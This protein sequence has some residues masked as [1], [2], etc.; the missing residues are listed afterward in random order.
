VLYEDPD[1]YIDTPILH[2]HVSKANGLQSVRKNVSFEPY[3]IP[4]RTH[5]AV[6]AH[7]PVEDKLQYLED[8]SCTKVDLG[9][10]LVR[11][12]L[13]EGEDLIVYIRKLK[14]TKRFSSQSFYGLFWRYIGRLHAGATADSDF[15]DLNIPVEKAKKKF[16]ITTSIE[17]GLVIA[18][19]ATSKGEV[20]KCRLV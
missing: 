10:G 8:K 5:E 17:E 7:N 15:I 13:S 6:L 1:K 18:W 20:R 4:F 16:S 9:A 11:V 2:T 14:H 3:L 12:A 19:V